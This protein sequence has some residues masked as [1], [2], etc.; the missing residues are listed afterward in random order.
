MPDLVGDCL[1]LRGL[2]NETYFYAL[3]GGEFSGLMTAEKNF[4]AE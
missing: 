4:S 3:I 2:L 1:M